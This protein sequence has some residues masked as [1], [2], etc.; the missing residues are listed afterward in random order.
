MF[1]SLLI[2]NRGEIARRIIRTARRMGIRSIAVVTEADRSWPHWREADEAVPIGSYLSVE[3]VVAAGL[4]TGAKAIHPGYGF[5]S[6]NA[7]FAEACAAA[8]ITFVG[9]PPVVIRAMGSKADAKALMQL[10]GVPVLPGYSGERQDPYF[11]RQKAY[12]VG[13]PVV[14]KAVAGGGGRGMRRIDRAVDFEPE[15]AAAKR[16]ALA[17]F[18][19]DRML[20]ERYVNAPRHIEVQV[21]ADAHGNAITQPNAVHLFERDCSLQRRHQKVIEESPAPGAST[22]LRS[23]LGDV[24][25]RATKAVG[26]QGAGTVEFVADSEAG[27]KQD[28]IFFIG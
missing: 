18:G 11:L 26:Y 20:V 7:V 3:D 1:D 16:E 14:V 23:W 12:E 17:A 8:G 25:V 6:E 28:S 10:A 19:D 9:P 15:L 13:Y 24:A 5:L 2:A 21:F 4:K 27:I 22:S